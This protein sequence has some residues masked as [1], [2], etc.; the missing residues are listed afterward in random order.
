MATTTAPVAP[1][2]WRAWFYLVWLSWQR[3]ARARQMVWIALGLLGFMAAFVAFNTAAGYWDLRGRR[4]RVDPGP[5]QPTRDAKGTPAPEAAPQGP[6]MTT[7]GRQT[8]QA[9]AA[10]YVLPRPV[11]GAPDMLAVAAAQAVLERSAFFVFARAIA[12]ALFLGF[13]LPVWSLAFATEALGGDRETNSLVWLLSRPLPRPA[14]YL[15]KFVALLPWTIGL[16]VG[17][18][19]L[20]CVLAGEPGRLAL[21]LFW[22]A[23][24]WGTLA[25]AALFHLVGAFF[26]RPAV[27]GVVYVFFLEIILNLMPGYMKRISISFYARCLMFDAAATYGVQPNNPLAF[28]AVEAAT[29]QAVL[30]LVTVGLLALGTWLF[31]RA[32]FS[33][34]V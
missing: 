9:Q 27:V 8:E 2:A 24:V 31:A 33:D 23:V 3:Q 34:G 30:A 14:I 15:A 10:L 5:T 11:P 21:R 12:L 29:A 22:P 20:I 19:A 13:L 1:S 28:L 32:Q 26:R 17:G 25:F 18:F 7:V 4:F 16:N 6:L